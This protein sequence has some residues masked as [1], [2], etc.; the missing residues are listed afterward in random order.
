[1]VNVRLPPETVE[2]IERRSEEMGYM[3]RS[4]FMRDAVRQRLRR[5]EGR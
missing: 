5:E 4:E 3:S 1:M 2:E